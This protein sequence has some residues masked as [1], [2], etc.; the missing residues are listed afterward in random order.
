MPKTKAKRK[1]KKTKVKKS[2]KRKLVRKPKKR[3]TA[4]AVGRKYIIV[5][6]GK[7]PLGRVMA[8]GAAGGAGVGFGVAAGH[9][10]GEWVFD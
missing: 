9:E 7:R 4:R 6:E 2:A 5:K 8:E 10:F 3:A 1:T